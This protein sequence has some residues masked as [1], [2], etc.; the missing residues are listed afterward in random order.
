M[1][2]VT[3]GTGLFDGLD[4]ELLVEI[5]RHTGLKQRVHSATAVCKAWRQ[6]TSHQELFTDLELCPAGGGY[7]SRAKGKLNIADSR[8]LS[9]V[10]WLPKKGVEVERLS[11]NTGDKHSNLSSDVT[12]KMLSKLASLTKL[13]LHGKKVTAAVLTKAAKLPFASR[14]TSFSY[15]RRLRTSLRT[16]APPHRRARRTAL[17]TQA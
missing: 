1:W 7:T 4:V 5:L 8:L 3:Q 16:A 13:K 11:L 15:C 10:Q 14:L 17:R 12:K 9:F 2:G 6:L